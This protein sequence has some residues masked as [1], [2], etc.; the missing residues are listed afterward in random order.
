MPFDGVGPMA[1]ICIYCVVILAIASGCSRVDRKGIMSQE[2][3]LTVDDL[4]EIRAGERNHEEVLLQYKYYD[5]PKMEAYLNT[6]AASLADVS[7]RPNLPYRVVILD[8]DEV[9]MF[10]GPGGFIYVTSGLLKFVESESEMAGLLAHEIAHISHFDYSNI[11][12]LTKMQ[13][14]YKGLLRGTE[15][16]RDSIGS[17]GT[18]AYYG[19]KG[20]GKVAPY[21][22][23]QFAA[24]QEI[25]ADDLAVKFLKKAGYDPRGLHKAVEKLAKVKKS[26]VGRYVIY[27]D[28]HP[29]FQDRRSAL[30]DNLEDYD[31]AAGDIEIKQDTLNEMRQM[32]VNTPDSIVFQP[33]LEFG[34]HS[35][36]PMMTQNQSKETMNNSPERKRL[37]L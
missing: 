28:V 10:G 31:P 12:Q 23:G 37:W 11:P 22:G 19:V 27:M 15:L 6:I 25:I 20:I 7:T 3:P 4:A 33:R 14:V 18:A 8:E 24:D 1:R 9:N 30:A 13:T 2:L 5:S 17:Y 26:E 32:M 34:M 16:A 35:A 21:V 29:P 36:D